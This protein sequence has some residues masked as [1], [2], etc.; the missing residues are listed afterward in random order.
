MSEERPQIS[1]IG[2]LIR[3]QR[4]RQSMTL[5]QLS[6]ATGCAISTL[7]ALEARGRGTT[8][9]IDLISAHLDL[10]F[11]GLPAGHEP[12]GTRIRLKRT[13]RGW[14][15]LQASQ[16][17]NVSPGALRRLEAGQTARVATLDRLLTTLAPGFRLREPELSRFA[18]GR[19]DERLTTPEMWAKIEAVIGGPA[20][21]DPCAHPLS[22]V[23]AHIRYFPTD[24]GLKQH[25]N[26][27]AYINPPYSRTERYVI[28]ALDEWQ[29]GRLKTAIMLLQANLER[30]WLHDRVLGVADL[31]IFKATI[32]FLD[33][34][35]GREVRVPGSHMICVLGGSEG[36]VADLMSAFPC[37]LVPKDARRSA[38]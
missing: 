7:H 24:D 9:I 22:P 10:R 5:A 33:E 16:R 1:L 21:V 36:L 35:A 31:L 11:I 38:A 25:W 32:R 20:D 8:D 3:Q 29:A 6:R 17:A 15:A 18:G 37:V 4:K 12:L 13:E 27:I 30:H 23:R 14:T 34:K 26:G 28:K 2:S 19:R